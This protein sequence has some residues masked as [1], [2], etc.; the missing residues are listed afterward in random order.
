MTDCFTS[1][2]IEARS[3]AARIVHGSLLRQITLQPGRYFDWM[4]FLDVLAAESWVGPFTGGSREGCGG[5]YGPHPFSVEQ[6]A[7]QRSRLVPD[8][9][10]RDRLLIDLYRFRRRPR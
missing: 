5:W 2:I 1:S 9:Q 4:R 8:G 7:E 3:F 10:P 6:M